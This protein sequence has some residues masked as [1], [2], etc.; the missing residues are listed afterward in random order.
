MLLSH[1]S[2]RILHIE[3]EVHGGPE[4]SVSAAVCKWWPV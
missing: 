3:A 1:Q 4:S 2:V